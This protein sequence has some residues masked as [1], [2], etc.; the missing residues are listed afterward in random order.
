MVALDRIES[1]GGGQKTL[2]EDSLNSRT[3]ALRYRAIIFDLDGTLLDT[4]DDLAIAGNQVL[5]AM[6]QS[7]HPA[8]RYRYFVGDGLRTMMTR[9]L[10]ESLRNPTGLET[11]MALFQKTYAETWYQRSAPYPGIT[12]L[13]NQLAAAGWPMSIL[14]NKPHDFTRA[15]VQRLLPDWDFEPLLGQ[16][17]D[18]PKKPDPAAALEIAAFFDYKPTDILYV[19]DTAV[20]MQ[21]ASAAGMDAVGVLW[22]FRTR[23]ELQAAGA[24][25]LISQPSQLLSLLTP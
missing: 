12:D 15:C 14:S 20:D 5:A 8:A 25:Y 7:E 24:R 23:E 9:I 19:G 18:V 13:L 11:A 21:T 6:G 3:K 2:R 22:G 16:R 17:P 4:L 1:Y 10:P